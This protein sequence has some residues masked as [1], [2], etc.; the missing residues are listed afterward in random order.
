MP[1]ASNRL[2]ARPRG[3]A[4]AVPAPRRRMPAGSPPADADTLCRQIIE[5]VVAQSGRVIL[6]AVISDQAK[7]D[8]H[9]WGSL[10]KYLVQRTIQPVAAPGRPVPGGDPAEVSA[11]RDRRAGGSSYYPEIAR[12]LGTRLDPRPMPTSP[13]RWGGRRRIMQRVSLTITAPTDGIFRAHLLAGSGISCPWTR[14]RTCA[15]SAEALGLANGTG[16][17]DIELSTSENDGLRGSQ[18]PPDLHGIQIAA[19]FGRP[20]LAV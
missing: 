20:G 17:V 14:E 18:W 6:D 8:D 15:K 2:G 13:T 10:G 11:G 5:Q 16:A 1:W 4:L 9:H 3:S 12:R 19:T 7:I